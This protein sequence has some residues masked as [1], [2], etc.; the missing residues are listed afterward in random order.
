MVIFN[1][2]PEGTHFLNVDLD[3]YS[4]SDLQPLIDALGKK[5]I[6]LHAGRDK[7]TY[8]AHLEIAKITRTAD[9]T[10][11]AFCTLI[12]ALPKAPRELWNKAKLRDFNIG[13]QADKE[14]RSFELDVQ[15]KTLEAVARL[16]GRIVLTVY[17][18]ETET[19]VAMKKPVAKKKAAAK[20]SL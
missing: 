6:L 2:K 5:V 16:G 17:A 3:I 14:P 20:K 13:V 19:V 15:T 8:S 9:A 1:G 12:D 11:L 10:M 18:P 4:A 7:K